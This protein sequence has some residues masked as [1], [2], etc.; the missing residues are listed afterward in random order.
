MASIPY[1]DW[2]F[3]ENGQH[4][5]KSTTATIMLLPPRKTKPF[6]IRHRVGPSKIKL[7]LTASISTN[8]APKE[9]FGAADECRTANSEQRTSHVHGHSKYDILQ[10]V[11]WS[12]KETVDLLH[13]DWQV[14]LKSW[15]PFL[16]SKQ[17]F[18]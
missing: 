2:S 11:T 15:G 4:A 16:R 3:K 13:V 18:K 9:V 8:E 12:P 1:R 7:N 6:W 10:P 14:A 17:S 5:W